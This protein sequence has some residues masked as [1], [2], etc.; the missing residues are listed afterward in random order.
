MLARPEYLAQPIE[1]VTES[2]SIDRNFGTSRQQ[3][4]SRPTEWHL[5]SFSADDTFPNKMH[6]VWLMRQ[7]ARWGHL[8]PEADVAAISE[9]CADTAPYRAAAASLGIRCPASDFIPM[10]LRHGQRFDLNTIVERTGTLTVSPSQR[11]NPGWR[12]PPLKSPYT[13]VLNARA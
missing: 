12:K 3:R 8:H 2:L 6:P 9:Q 13:G 1:L 4:N 5:R 7:M 10:Q 11:T